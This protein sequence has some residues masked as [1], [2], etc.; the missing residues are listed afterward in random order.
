MQST[1][2]GA[3][4]LAKRQETCI[5]GRTPAG[6]TRFVEIGVNA[7]H[8]PAPGGHVTMSCW[9]FTSTGNC[10]PLRTP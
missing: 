8:C 9:L 5:P 10:S 2:N 1:N 4:M 7:K 6:Y 3:Y